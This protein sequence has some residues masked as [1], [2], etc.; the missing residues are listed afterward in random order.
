M[1]GQFREITD[2]TKASPP[3][4]RSKRDDTYANGPKHKHLLIEMATTTTTNNTQTMQGTKVLVPRLVIALP[5]RHTCTS[6]PALLE[7]AITR[8]AASTH[9]GMGMDHFCI[10]SVTHAMHALRVDPLPGV[11]HVRIFTVDTMRLSTLEALLWCEW[12]RHMTLGVEPSALLCDSIRV[13]V[14]ACL[15]GDATPLHTDANVTLLRKTVLNLSYVFLPPCTATSG[16][17]PLCSALEQDA[18]LGE[19]PSSVGSDA[20]PA[21]A[22]YWMLHTTLHGLVDDLASVAPTTVSAFRLDF[23]SGRYLPVVRPDTGASWIMHCPQHMSE[24]A[25]AASSSSTVTLEHATRDSPAAWH[26]F[27]APALCLSG[28]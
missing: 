19:H 24:T 6:L 18:R 16:H 15:M 8:A 26:R 11:D 5:N 25:S 4:E 3:P 13:V 23:A 27:N 9:A 17:T 28:Q 1:I 12:Q 14:R 20:T 10:E 22:R 2:T 7:G 21:C